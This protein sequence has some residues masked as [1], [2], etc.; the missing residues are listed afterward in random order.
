MVCWSTDDILLQVSLCRAFG[1]IELDAN[2]TNCHIQS[3]IRSSYSLRQGYRNDFKLSL[4]WP[5]SK[6]CFQKSYLKL[7]GFKVCGIPVFHRKNQW[8]LLH[9]LALP[10][11]H[12]KRKQ[13]SYYF[14]TRLT[15]IILRSM[16]HDWSCLRPKS[17]I[18]ACE[19][20]A[21]LMEPLDKYIHLSSALPIRVHRRLEYFWSISLE[22]VLKIILTWNMSWHG[23][24]KH[25]ANSEAHKTISADD[26]ITTLRWR[27]R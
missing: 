1:L 13:R 5:Q 15:V 18:H 27:Q 11:C 12:V 10:P 14:E 26:Y 24:G 20:L 22:L 4:T 21:I 17:R 3:G 25:P 19:S 2:Q 16:I 7:Q 6:T 8:R 9:W 23:Q